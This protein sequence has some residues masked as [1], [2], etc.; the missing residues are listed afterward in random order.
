MKSTTISSQCEYWNKHIQK[1]FFSSISAWILAKSFS[2]FSAL[3]FSS[4]CFCLSKSASCLRNISWY[5]KLYWPYLLTAWTV[6]L[7]LPRM[8]RVYVTRYFSLAKT[9][10]FSFSSYSFSLVSISRSM[11]CYNQR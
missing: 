7:T 3:I 9:M 4:F 11:C 8:P 2:F 10:I 5:L 6:L 1:F